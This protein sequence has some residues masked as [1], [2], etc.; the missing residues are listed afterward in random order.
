MSRFAH[1]HAE[2]PCPRCDARLA[3]ENAIGF[4][5][6]YCPDPHGGAYFTYRVGEP[7]LWRLDSRK[8]VPAWAYFLGGDANIGDPSFAD[9][10]VRESE[11]AIRACAI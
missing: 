6:G 11:Y 7:L 2:L 1:V 5:W 3:P 8:S 4:Q 9:L 10:L